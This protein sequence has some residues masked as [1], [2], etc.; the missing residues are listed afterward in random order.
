[1]KDAIAERPHDNDLVFVTRAKQQ[2]WMHGKTDAVCLEFGKLTRRLGL[3]NPGRS[4]YSLRHSFRTVADVTKDQRA[5]R[6]VMGH[7]DHS[8]DDHYVHG[9]DDSR[10]IAVSECVRQWLF[11]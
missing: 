10:L 11:Q 2:S 8:I 9:V 4:F 5:I 6:L 7:T 3:S 1:L